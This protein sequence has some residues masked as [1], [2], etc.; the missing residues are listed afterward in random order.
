MTGFVTAVEGPLDDQ[1]A[2][3]RVPGLDD[4]GRRGPLRV[5]SRGTESLSLDREEIDVSDVAGIVDPGQAEAVAR[6]LR[7]LLERRFD[8]ES[9]LADCLADLD[10]L[11][12]D[13]GLDALGGR[14]E[15]P[16]FLARPRAV[17]VAA[18]VNRYRSL[19]LA[20]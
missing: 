18:A 2:V 9:T 10:A 5:R 17:D 8:G 7:A 12:D 13:E 15:R 11:L 3:V 1:V 6:A 19:E 16:A 20:D 14:M 4:A